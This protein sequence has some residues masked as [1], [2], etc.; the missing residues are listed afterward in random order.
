MKDKRCFLPVKILSDV[1]VPMISSD[2]ENNWYTTSEFSPGLAHK[3][4]TTLVA[5][6]ACLKESRGIK[7][8]YFSEKHSPSHQQYMT[9][10][11]PKPKFYPECYWWIFLPW[12]CLDCFFF[13]KPKHIFNIHGLPFYILLTDLSMPSL[14]TL[15]P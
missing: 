12:N 9:Q 4:K 3:P 2:A 13:F 7:Y 10:G 11:F 15:I 8:Q 1:F 6:N 5:K 14:L